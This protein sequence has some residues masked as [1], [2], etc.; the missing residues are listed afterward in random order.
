MGTKYEP[1]M[2][3]VLKSIYFG[4]LEVGVITNIFFFNGKVIF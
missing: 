1:G 4:N 3:V 2:V